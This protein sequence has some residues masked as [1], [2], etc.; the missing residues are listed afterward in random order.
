MEPIQNLPGTVKGFEVLYFEEAEVTKNRGGSPSFATFGPMSVLYFPHYGRYILQINDWRYP[1]L[2]RFSVSSGGNG[3]YTLPG[4]NGSSFDLKITKP[5][6]G[7][8]NLDALLE[9]TRKLEASPDDKLVRLAKK[10]H[11]ET[12]P[13]EVI[14]ET[15]KQVGTK[16]KNKVATMKTGT[17]YL[18]STKRRID[19][20]SL[21]NKNFK[22]EARSTFKKDFFQSGEKMTQQFNQ[23]RRENPTLGQ[24][25][26][27]EDLR[28]A[29]HGA[30][31][32]IPQV[33]VEEAILNGKDY[34]VEKKGIDNMA[35]R[36]RVAPDAHATKTTFAQSIPDYSG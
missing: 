18:T 29:T 5:G 25:M 36:E 20:K 14:S 1:L 6:Q 4:P 16:I 11:A 34:V 26:K 10:T 28:K 35:G 32:Y 21:K 15:L 23:S 19:M 7:L 9:G 3:S 24:N 27:F 2:R 8:A 30:V 33:D 31:F 22:R 13:K 17:K 12:G